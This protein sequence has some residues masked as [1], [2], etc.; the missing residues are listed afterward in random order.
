[1]VL[2]LHLLQEMAVGNLK[3]RGLAESLHHDQPWALTSFLEYYVPAEVSAQFLSFSA[4]AFCLVS[5]TLTLHLHNLETGK[6]LGKGIVCRFLLTFLFSFLWAFF[7]LS[8]RHFGFPKV[9]SV[10]PVQQ[11]F[12]FL[13]GLYSPKTGTKPGCPQGQNLGG[14][15]ACASLSGD[16]IHWLF[17]S[18][19]I[20]YF[21]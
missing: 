9:Q 15:G 20:K 5:W 6:C 19:S 17:N 10:S 21:V 18:Y 14:C 12:C 13:Q 11:D 16:F 7:S 3:W 4:V 2:P 8:Q 1:M